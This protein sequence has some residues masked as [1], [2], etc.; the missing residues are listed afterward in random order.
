MEGFKIAYRVKL[1]SQRSKKFVVQKC[2][3]SPSDRELDGHYHALDT[4]SGPLDRDQAD[5]LC[6]RLNEEEDSRERR[7]K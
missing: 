6:E 3:V 5:A 1:R 7:E 4:V 2:S